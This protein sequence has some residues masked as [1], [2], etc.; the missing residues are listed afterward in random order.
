MNAQI[1]SKKKNILIVSVRIIYFV[2]FFTCP[3][4]DFRV[5]HSISPFPLYF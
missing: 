3:L 5:F 2:G 4:R 1:H